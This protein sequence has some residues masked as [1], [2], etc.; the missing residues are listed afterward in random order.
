[1]DIFGQVR[2]GPR[3]G[4]VTTTHDLGLTDETCYP[5]AKYRSKNA[6]SVGCEKLGTVRRLHLTAHAP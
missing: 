5:R 1:M 2:A 6:A 3:A 4:T